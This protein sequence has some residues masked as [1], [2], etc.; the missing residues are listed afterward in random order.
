MGDGDKPRRR[1]VHRYAGY[2]WHARGDLYE[3]LSAFAEAN[4]V[5]RSEALNQLVAEAL[6]AHQNGDGI[7]AEDLV[8]LLEL[9][10][11]VLASVLRIEGR[12]DELSLRL[13]LLG[14]VA[15][16]VVHAVA[17]AT[18][19]DP[20]AQ[21]IGESREAAEEGVLAS[22]FE[23]SRNAWVLL[24]PAGHGGN[25]TV[26]EMDSGRSRKDSPRREIE[27][28][29][30]IWRGRLHT[31]QSVK[32][33][34]DD[35]TPWSRRRVISWAKAHGLEPRAVLS[36][37]AA[38]IMN[39]NR[40]GLPSVLAVSNRERLAIWSRARGV[41]TDV[42]LN[43]LVDLALTHVDAA[44]G[45][46]PWAL[47]SIKDEVGNVQARLEHCDSRLSAQFRQLDI[48][49]TF[50]AG[51][52]YVVAKW[53]AAEDGDFE[54]D[55]SHDGEQPADSEEGLRQSFARKSEELWEG[56]LAGLLKED[57]PQV[58]APDGGSVESVDEFEETASDEAD[59]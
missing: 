56:M 19:L 45:L 53:C 38:L 44:A 36:E 27:T 59:D 49:G 34:N 26:A 9:V 2:T 54:Y 40:N 30:D 50:L 11:A 17:Y 22:I 31:A 51:T 33:R 28:V 55:F 42:A 15:L 3:R 18:A 14:S 21:E 25:E 43:A 46:P 29:L 48:V 39:K 24:R 12:L 23:A 57:N 58:P 47:G 37:L 1:P 5:L 35:F 20:E 32:G 4:G 52:P 8:E 10:Q 6:E 16:T 13:D 41:R 7:K